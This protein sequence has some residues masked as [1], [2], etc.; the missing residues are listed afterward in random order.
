MSA[1][2]GPPPA[3]TRVPRSEAIELAQ[4][5]VT[6]LDPMCSRIV[7]AGS[8]RRQLATVG[9][10]DLVCI[11]RIEPMLDMFGEATGNGIDLLGAQLDNLCGEQVIRQRR[12]ARGRTSWGPRNKRGIYRDLPVDITECE[13]DTFGLHVLIRTGPAAY[14][15]AFVT[16]VRMTAIL[17]DRDGTVVGE[18]PGLL[19][20]GFEIKDGFRLYRHGGFV[21]TPDERDVY[22]LLGMAYVEPW[23]RR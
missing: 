21:P 23:S 8:I 20:S 18:R 7:A 14:A 22:D 9:D 12:D 4:E 15:H 10:I 16:P 19:P 17:R 11:P 2:S 6:L 13:A 1:T 5:L 3:S